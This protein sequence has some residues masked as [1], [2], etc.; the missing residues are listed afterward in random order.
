[1]VEAPYL[2]K[3][4]SSRR[5]YDVAAARFLTLDDLYLLIRDG[6]RI[7]AIDAEGRDITRTVLL[8]VLAEREE[9]GEPLLSTDTLHRLVQLYGSVMH[10]AFLRF[11]DE[12]LADLL[13]QQALIQGGLRKSLKR[14]GQAAAQVFAQQSAMFDAS[15]QLVRGLLSFGDRSASPPALAEPVAATPP[16]ARRPRGRPR[17][18]G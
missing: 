9:N 1:M 16:P 10:S 6:R 17:K 15:K 14:G 3:K 13:A 5:L 12:G 7:Q 2:I 8:Q 18:S 11:M 4:Y